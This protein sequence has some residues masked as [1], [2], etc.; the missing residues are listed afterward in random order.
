MDYPVEPGKDGMDE[1]VAQMTME[2]PMR[3]LLST[4]FSFAVLA[5]I[6]AAG[7][8][9]Y[10]QQK[11]EA[12]GPAVAP[13]EVEIPAG[14]G[15]NAIASRL[16]RAGAIENADIF[17]Y[18]TRF[19]QAERGLQA[20]EYEIP[21]AASM[22]EI[23]ALLQ[24]G[25][26]IER[27]VTIPEGFTSAQ[28]VATLNAA[29]NL[30]GEIAATPEEGTLAPETYFYTKGETRA[31]VI[32]RM[33]AAQATIIDEL[34]QARAADLPFDTKEE[35]L[36]LAS[37]VEK[38]TGVGSER[39]HVAGVFVNRLRKGMRLQTDPTVIYG[40][41]KGQGMDRP[42]TRSDLKDDNPYNTYIIKGLPPGPIA[43][44]GRAAIEAALNP[45][46]TKD[47]YFVADGTGGHAFARTLAEHNRNVAKWRKIER[48]RAN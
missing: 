28:I 43:H 6:T 4:L 17:R 23:L 41:T 22:A 42:I 19:K 5:A 21:P 15:L 1:D 47:L 18:A 3:R 36:I 45:M 34:W 46:E 30:T 39:A 29:E 35:A 27:R 9:Y 14:S 26:T 20:G 16:E 44:P 33:R 10:G 37:I 12:P 32:A 38:E 24:S 8:L 40:V 48:E 7:A 31:A 2:P 11:F 13:L 25:K